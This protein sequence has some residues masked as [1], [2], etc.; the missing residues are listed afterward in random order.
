MTNDAQRFEVRGKW[1]LPD[2][3]EHKVAGTLHFSPDEGA[4]LHL[5]GTLDSPM[6]ADGV[7]PRIHGIA[8]GNEFNLEDCFQVAFK[9]NMLD[10]DHATES[11]RAQQVFKGVWFTHPE[12]PNANQMVAKIRYLT[13][14]IG[15]RGIGSEFHW[16]DGFSGNTEKLVATI[17][18]YA[19]PALSATLSS[20]ITISLQHHV[21]QKMH[22]DM[23]QTLLEWRVA[24]L[25]FPDLISTSEATEHMSDVQDL[26]SIAC[27]RTAE[28]DEITFRHPDV[29]ADPSLSDPKYQAPIH[30]YVDW[31]AR[32]HSKKPGR[33]SAD[34][35]FF[36]FDDLGGMEGVCKWM[37]SAKRH[38]STLGRVMASR[39]RKGL[40][41]EDKIFHSIAAIEAFARDR[42]GYSGV[43]L[44]GA[45]E[46]CCNLA[47][48]EFA[49]LVG[50]VTEWKRVA[51]SHRDDIGHHYGRRPDQSGSQK[52]F[53][54]ESIYWLFVLCMLRDSGA[55]DLVFTRISNHHVWAWLA[56]KVQSVVQAG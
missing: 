25:K 3:E 10:P 44:P 13:Q 20:G 33:I 52:Y 16:Q 50:D 49:S 51:K 9:S 46:H 43:K 19:Q 48:A 11:V 56:P 12:E 23:E 45:L 14:W 53:L 4:K 8:D 41:M 7:Y 55:P 26:V 15:H 21:K 17:R 1:W 18:A 22:S 27:G 30:L 36:T 29:S 28:Y 42:I 38:R 6:T 5:I 40:F 31:I 2:R 39:Y 32:D 54:A 34:D 24:S 35:M 37:E 47:G